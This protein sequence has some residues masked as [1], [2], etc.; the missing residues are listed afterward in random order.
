MN[1]KEFK[2]NLDSLPASLFIDKNKKS[3]DYENFFLVLGVVFNDLKGLMMFDMLIKESY[4]KPEE[5]EVSSHTGEY[6]G[7]RIQIN[8]FL[9]GVI[10]EFL[11]FLKSN[12]GTMKTLEFQ[13][14]LKNL[15]PEHRKRWTDLVDV[16]MKKNTSDSEILKTLVNIRNNVA[17][18]YYQSGKVLRKG[19]ID[20]F[21]N[22]K[23]DK[24]Q[25]KKPY[26]SVGETM[27]S[28]RFYYSDAS[29]EAYTRS[30]LTKEQ[31]ESISNIVDDMNSTITALM[32]AYI[33]SLKN[34]IKVNNKPKKKKR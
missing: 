1:N 16:A 20:V 3:D 4:R 28:T 32:T 5:G 11:E 14:L 21:N 6:G 26:F 9:I 12:E 8:K 34:K 24:P 29:V 19:F 15:S 30:V 18:H 13:L 23:D 25:Y 27:E 2:G 31:V 33:T 7:A 10:N 17:F 22:Q